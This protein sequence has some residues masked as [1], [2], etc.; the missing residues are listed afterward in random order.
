MRIVTTK[1]TWPGEKRVA[2]VPETVK[3][4]ASLGFDLSLESG[5]GLQA[6]FTDSEYEQAGATIATDAQSTLQEADLVLAVRPLAAD[7]IAQIPTSAV[8]LGFLDPYRQTDTVNACVAQGLTAISLEMVP[9]STRAQK[10]DGLSSQASLAGYA[11]MIVAAFHLPRIFPLMMTP[12]GTLS[13]A[14]VFIIGAGVAGLQAIA[15]AHR[16]GARIEAFDTRPVVKEEVQSLGARFLEVDLGELGQTE[17]GYAQELTEEQ[18]QRQTQGMAEAIARS[19]IVV[20]TAQVFGRPAP[21]I[22]TLEMVK[23]MQ[24]TS[25]VIDMAVETG[26]NVEG[27]QVDQI[28]EIDGVKV[29]GMANLPSQVAGHASE[30]YASNLFEYVNEFKGEEPGTLNLEV[31]DEILNASIVVRNGELVNEQLKEVY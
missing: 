23:S 29:I 21:R 7:V 20:T 5:A 10:L 13:P 14:R 28:T 11:A 3:K 17:Q 15:T 24:P 31:D 26:G 27:S 25:V 4:L 22:V 6:G 1:E 9:R 16:L 18:Q 30:M 2:L 19:D 8:Y 12:A